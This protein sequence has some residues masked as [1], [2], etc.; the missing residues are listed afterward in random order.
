MKRYFNLAYFLFLIL[1]VSCGGGR[2]GTLFQVKHFNIH[3]LDDLY[4]FL[5]YRDD[6]YPLIS[7]HRGG[8]ESGYPENAIET[9]SNSTSR[10]AIIIECD[11]AM[12][13]D[14]VLVLMHDDKLDRTTT[15]KGLLQSFT[16]PELKKLY[17]KDNAGKQTEFRIPLL[18]EVLQWGKGRV[19]FTL[20]VKR[21]VPFSRVIEVIR[22]NNAPF[23]SVI[24][25]YNAN[26]AAEVHRLAP[27]LLISASIHTTDDLER[28]NEYGVPD[29][30]LL[31]FVGT[32]EPEPQVYKRLH[33]HGILCILGTLGNLD[34]QAI[35]RGDELYY[36]MIGRGAD[37]LSTDRPVE[38]GK[39]LQQYRRD[40]KIR[41]DYVQ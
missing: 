10:Q 19:I 2:S 12:T 25:T 21:G 23:C 5:T 9:F 35:R 20:D 17:L 36:D 27:D 13:K 16:L 38:A 18:D 28:L 32:S 22:R 30:R 39:Q 37:I 34:N 3:N 8:P 7:A 29:N 15:G 40:K 26:Q 24:I 6:R 41:N 14:S 1:F 11:I 33:D 31:A 4:H